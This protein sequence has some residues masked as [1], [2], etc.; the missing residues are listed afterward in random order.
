MTTNSDAG[1]GQDTRAAVGV[2][3]HQAQP[4]RA[5]MTGGQALVRSLK[6][7]DIDVVFGLPGVQLDG[8]FDALWE[9][10]D[11][12]RVYHTRHEQAA[13]YMADGYARTTGRV[14]TCLVVPGPGIL[15][16]ASGLS[17]AYACSSPVL[18]V[19]GQIPFKSIG[20]GRGMLHEI[21][22]QLG[23]ARSFS[24]WGGQ[25][26]RPEDVPGVMHEAFR[27]LQSG[28]P[29]PVVVEVPQDVLLNGG[30]VALADRV[31]PEREAGDPDAIEKAAE[32]LGRSERAVIFTGGGVLRSGAWT[33]LERLAA[34]LE[35]PVIMSS[36]G[37]GA[38]S[39]R[40]Y[41]AQT[42]V[43]GPE[44]LPP[45][46]VVLIVGT[47]FLQ[48]AQ[49][50]WRP[51]ADQSVIQIDVDPE[52][53]GRNSPAAT[54]IVGDAGMV[55]QELLA[56]I[57]RHNR[58]RASRRE[59]CEAVRRKVEAVLGALE[60]QRSY[61]HAIR[62]AL[63]ED[64]IVV[65]GVTQLGYWI[66]F[67]TFPIYRPRTLITPGYQGTL[68]YEYG[69]A[70]GAQVG[71]PAQRVVAI[72]GD[73]GFMYQVGEL[74]T[75]VRHRINAIAIVFN[76]GAF[77]N[78]RRMQEQIYQGHLIASDLHNPDF[79]KLADAFGLRGFRADG[80][81]GLR[82]QLT[83]ALREDAPALI[84]VPVGPMPY[85]WPVIRPGIER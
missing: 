48:P 83:A 22:D 10:R 82:T 50:N 40:N 45:A 15:N 55:L 20:R 30:D 6:V 65:S 3:G 62:D 70:L 38:V 17:T 79:M 23:A 13:A 37:R 66:Q 49:S 27:Q 74:A 16:A 21:P 78:V 39:D 14:G 28:H 11:A 56:R 33:S 67:G 46:D 32:T 36:S 47:R 19:A 5:K 4:V 63:P 58:R 73:G 8:A 77:G 71:A 41:L 43:A 42:M 24:K 52:E 60:P 68:G 85:L 7:Q 69:T 18:C 12:V 2:A 84:E 64:G 9:A 57:P 54:G 80:P 75:A 81:E 34:M 53:I 1:R 26:G 61:A 25:A 59:E 35:A 51:R 76:D 44:L 29:R 31:E 72:C